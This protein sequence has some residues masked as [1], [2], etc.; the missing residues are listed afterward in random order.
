MKTVLVALVCFLLGGTVFFGITQ[1]QKLQ[2]ENQEL[3]MKVAQPLPTPE[4][5]NIQTNMV[6]PTQA[7]PM[8]EKAQTGSIEGSLGYPSSGIPELSVYA[9]NSQDQT[10]YVMIQTVVN[11]TTFTISDVPAGTYYVVAYPKES[12][13]AGGYTQMVPCGLSVDCKD[14]SF[15]PVIV[16]PGETAKGVEVKDWYA[17]EGTFPKKP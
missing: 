14:H 11:Q 7:E 3:K 2:K 4:K 1:Y 9:L 16:K 12:G 6:S 5:T 13:I 17:P 15:I 8:K 10:K